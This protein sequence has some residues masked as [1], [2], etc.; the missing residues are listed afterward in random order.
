[1]DES[2]VDRVGEGWTYAGDGSN[3]GHCDVLVSS[4]GSEELVEEIRARID[5]LRLW[6]GVRR[7]RGEERESE[8]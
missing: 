6:W 1:M 2:P 4:E 3:G 8:R 7:E 5:L